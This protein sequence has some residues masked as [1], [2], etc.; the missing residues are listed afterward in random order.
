[1][2]VHVIIE[3]SN[4]SFVLHLCYTNNDFIIM[5]SYDEDDNCNDSVAS[6][7]N[8]YLNSYKVLFLYNF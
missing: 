5:L 6:S 7:L 1:M 2:Q 4:E 8:A 3:D